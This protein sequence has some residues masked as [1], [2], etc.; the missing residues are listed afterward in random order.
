MK[1]RDESDP[2]KTTDLLVGTPARGHRLRD[3]GHD[4][5]QTGLQLRSI[6]TDRLRLEKQQE[7]LSR[8]TREIIRRAEEAH[9]EIQAAL[10]ENSALGEIR[11]SSQSGASGPP[12]VPIDGR[13]IC[14]VGSQAAGRGGR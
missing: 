1:R 14:I 6:R 5:G 13:F 2:R 4:V 9:G 11:G 3:G 12:V 10:D 8:A 7:H